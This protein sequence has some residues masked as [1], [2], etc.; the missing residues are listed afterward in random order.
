MH[1]IQDNKEPITSAILDI[2]KLVEQRNNI[3]DQISII[4][5]EL[6][7]LGISSKIISKVLKLRKD[8]NI[9]DQE[10]ALANYINN[11]F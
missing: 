1:N 11:L 10:A 6:K 5:K 4:K 2:E 7:D 3:N 8:K 9:E